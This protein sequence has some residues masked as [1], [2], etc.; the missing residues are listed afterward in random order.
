[1]TEDDIQWLREQFEFEFCGMCGGDADEHVVTHAIF[2]L[3]FA[4]CLN[5]EE[6]E[7]T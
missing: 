7:G 1:M 6:E 4:Y 2:G 3:P 5:G